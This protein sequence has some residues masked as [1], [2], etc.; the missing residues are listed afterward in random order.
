MRIPRDLPVRCRE[1][2]T[3]MPTLIEP[4][5]VVRLDVA[6]HLRSCASCFKFYCC[7]KMVI[8]R[9]GRASGSNS[10]E[11]LV[12]GD[13]AKFGALRTVRMGNPVLLAFII[14]LLLAGSGSMAAILHPTVLKQIGRSS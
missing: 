7:Y 4:M 8:E 12:S 5:G 6:D 11:S 1:F 10:I 13:I 14:I 2:E 9:L 3:L